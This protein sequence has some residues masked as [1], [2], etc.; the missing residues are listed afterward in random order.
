MTQYFTS[1]VRL[2]AVLVV[3]A[4]LVTIGIQLVIDT[5]VNAV[6]ISVGAA[7]IGPLLVAITDT[8]KPRWVLFAFI[9]SL[10]G[11]G[12]ALGAVGFPAVTSPTLLFALA[13]TLIVCITAT[14][15]QAQTSLEQ[16]K[17]RL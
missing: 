11:L 6:V 16:P 1:L 4:N 8:K 9:G 13:V 17:N 12:A 7:S 5:S 14:L 15:I 2:A 3:V 10:M